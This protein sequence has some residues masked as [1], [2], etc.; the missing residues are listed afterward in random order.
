ML[1]TIKRA[2]RPRCCSNLNR[3]RQ[4]EIEGD[5]IQYNYCLDLK[6]MYVPSHLPA[7]PCAQQCNQFKSTIF[8][9]LQGTTPEHKLGAL[10]T[11]FVF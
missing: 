4:T 10:I 11:F 3:V 7:A 2:N 6:G 8:G 9:R 5:E 1:N